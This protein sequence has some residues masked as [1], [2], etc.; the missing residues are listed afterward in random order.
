MLSR[1]RKENAL[2][3]VDFALADYLLKEHPAHNDIASLLI[4][5]SQATRAGHLCIKV[6]DHEVLP[7]LEEVWAIQEN[8]TL[9]PKEWEELEKL[10]Q[11]SAKNLPSTLISIVEADENFPNTPLCRFGNLFYFQRYWIYESNCLQKFHHL[12]K[13]K[14]LLELNY[15]IVQLSLDQ[16]SLLPEQAQAIQQLERQ[17]LTIISGGPGTGKTYTAGLLVKIFWKGISPSQRENCKIALAAPTGKAAA[18]LQKSLANAVADL[19]DF[20]PIQATTLH[21]LLNLNSKIQKQPVLIS[22]DLLVI[23]E[24]SMIDI[25]LMSLLLQA[26]KP[27]ARL[28]MLGDPFQLPPI[29]VGAF[30]SDMV[31]LVCAPGD[32]IAKKSK[33]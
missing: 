20:P 31:Q 33:S 9:S 16:L 27:G 32:Q 22:A 6:D 21:A 24:C 15:S 17:A 3:F 5:L 13:E 23:D 2:P 10:I 14:P 18:N 25:R 11:A 30:F 7:K 26:L 8:I 4:H 1:L 12:L 29:E 19:Q 28:I